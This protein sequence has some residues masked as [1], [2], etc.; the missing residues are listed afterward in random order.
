[1][2]PSRGRVSSQPKADDWLGLS[3]YGALARTVRDSALLLDVMHGA[4]EGDAYL[5]PRFHGRYAEAAAKPRPRLRIAV[6]RKVPPPFMARLSSGQRGA[7]ERTAKLLGELGHEVIER[8]PA[9]GLKVLEFVQTWTRGIYEESR[10]VPD[11]SKLERSTRQLVA[12]GRSL[13]P[14]RRRE[15]LLAKRPATTAGILSLWGEC[16]VLLT[17]VLTRTAISA[18]GAYGRSAPVAMDRSGRF[19]PFNPIFNLTGQP[20]VAVPAGFGSDGLPLSV[21]LVGRPGAEDV[22]YSLAGQIET[23]RP[24]AEQRPPF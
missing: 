13:V 22:L 24:W 18:E 1:M 15:K 6:S 20:A 12:A 10:A 3:T 2:K 5:L 14:G 21:Q 8:D 9:Y 17:P 7:W 19:M 23:A 11:H 16:D 4:V